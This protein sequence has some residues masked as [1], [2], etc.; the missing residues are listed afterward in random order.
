MSKEDI[1]VSRVPLPVKADET[2]DVIEGFDGWNLYVP[3]WASATI[4]GDEM[5][6]ENRDPHDYVRATR[7]FR[8]S[9]RV[10]VSFELQSDGYLEIEL[11]P[12]FG[13]A[14][15]V[16]IVNPG[17]GTIEIDA[18][19][20]RGVYSMSVNGEKTLS[21]RSFEQS[22]DALHRISFRTGAYRNVGGANP[23]PFASDRPTH[24]TVSKIR[25]ARIACL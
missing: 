19:A 18:D 9:K 22:V 4:S 5:R 2:Q 11:L 17:S 1:W 7:V 16:T 24:P 3:K 20:K 14:R 21:D 6:L 10:K 12:K 23:I 8:E 13:S 15:P 25:K